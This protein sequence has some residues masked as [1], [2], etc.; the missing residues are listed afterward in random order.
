MMYEPEKKIEMDFLNILMNDEIR[1]K[2]INLSKIWGFNQKIHLEK[3]DT[4]MTSP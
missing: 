1:H 3:Y 4:P 2:F